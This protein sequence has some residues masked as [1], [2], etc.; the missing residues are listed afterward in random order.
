VSSFGLSGTNG[1]VILDRAPEPPSRAGADAG[2]REAPRLLVLSARSPAALAR[3]RAALADHLESPGVRL[4]DVAHTLAAGRVHHDVRTFVVASS[5][6]SAARQ[7]RAGTAANRVVEDGIGAAGEVRLLVGAEETSRVAVQESLPRLAQVFGRLDPEVEDPVAGLAQVV[8]A[9]GLVPART[10]ATAPV[11]GAELQ[12]GP[13][14]AVLVRPGD[15]DPARTL[16]EAVGTLFTAGYP[17]RPGL[18]SGPG[19]ALSAAL[20]TYPFERRRY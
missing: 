11:A 15:P 7:L 12:A 13:H 20:P 5:C 16:A 6:A 10:L 14:R 2:P 18:L 4:D 3:A 19:A 8:V 1:H 17:V 9:I